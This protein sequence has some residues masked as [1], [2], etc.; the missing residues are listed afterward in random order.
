MQRLDS[1]LVDLQLVSTRT[2]AQ[3]LIQQELVEVCE[4]GVW[5]VVNKSSAKFLQTANIRIRENTLQ[6]FVSRAGLKLEGAL[7]H[8]GLEVSGLTALDVGQSTGGF[9]DCLL[10][11][12]AKQVVGVDVGHDQLHNSLKGNANLICFEGLNA[13]SLSQHKELKSISHTIDCVVMDLSFISQKLIYPELCALIQRPF[14]LISLVK[15]QFEVGQA[16]IG[17][18]G[19]VK[20][21]ALY[22]VLERE[23]RE[24]LRD[25]GFTVLDYFDS[26]IKG[27]DGNKEFFVYARKK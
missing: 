26:P 22:V 7:T 3:K 27:G 17:K 4:A 15:P 2:L 8:T 9:S 25:L 19:I 18:G 6:K 21:A 12:G 13:R 14:Y 23:I 10:Q 11:N 24:E 1:L 20:N 5:K 16:G